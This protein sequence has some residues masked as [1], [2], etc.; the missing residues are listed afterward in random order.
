MMSVVKKHLSSSSWLTS[1]K[2]MARVRQIGT[3][4]S[5]VQVG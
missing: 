5:L 3:W 2:L 1:G 4:H